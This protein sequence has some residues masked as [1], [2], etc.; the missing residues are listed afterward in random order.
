MIYTQ[1]GGRKISKIALGGALFGSKIPKTQAFEIMDKF[2][3]TGGNAI[4]TARGYAAWLE[5]GANASENAIGEFM[6]SCSVREKTVVV[7]KGGLPREECF[8]VSRLTEKEVFSDVDESLKWLKTDYIDV[9][10]LHRDA[11]ETPVSE[12]MPF[13]HKLVK[14][15]K[16]L[17]LGASNWTAERIEEANAFALK[18]GL[19]PFS[20]SQ[21]KWSYAVTTA[22]AETDKT[23]VEMTDGEYARYR[24]NGV[25]VMAFSSQAQGFL[26]AAAE[27]GVENLSDFM[28]SRFVNDVNLERLKKVRRI[29]AETGLSPTAVGLGA[30]LFD[31]NVDGV[32][33]VGV[34]SVERLNDSL[35]ALRLPNGFL[36]ELT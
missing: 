35:S 19:T 21:I 29:A 13:L 36:R 11:P 33:I 1:I 12:I 6:K 14:S 30:L 25:K 23:I 5:G 28:K 7:T 8:D 24:K 31:T 22:G 4:D 32:P 34:S 15:G 9:Y 10:F 26:S 18:N 20:A 16:A 17:A 2:L 3:E 27:K